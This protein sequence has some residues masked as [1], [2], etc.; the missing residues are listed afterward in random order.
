MNLLK[1]EATLSSP[2]KANIHVHQLPPAAELELT[3]RVPRAGEIAADLV[4]QMPFAFAPLAHAAQAAGADRRGRSPTAWPA[5]SRGVRGAGGLRRGPAGPGGRP[6]GVPARRRPARGGAGPV[7]RRGRRRERPAALPAALD[8]A[9]KELE[10]VR[11]WLDTLSGRQETAA[12]AVRTLRGRLKRHHAARALAGPS[13]RRDALRG[14]VAAFL[15]DAAQELLSIAAEERAA[16]DTG[17][18]DTAAPRPA[19]P[20]LPAPSMRFMVA[21]HAP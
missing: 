8:A 12:D 6:A 15:A 14:R 7:R 19:P 16:A 10:D 9:A 4:V 13:K 2:S 1:I 20:H 11:R 3:V 5:T 18:A 21:R 17:Q